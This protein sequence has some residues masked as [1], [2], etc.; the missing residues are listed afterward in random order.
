MLLRRSLKLLGISGGTF[1]S[2]L[3]Q[4]RDDGKTTTPATISRWLTGSSPVEPAVMGWLRELLRQALRASNTPIIRWPA[5]RSITFAVGNLKGGVQVSTIAV[6]L[7]I[8]SK[9]RFGLRTTHIFASNDGRR[10]YSNKV[11]GDLGIE[12]VAL[13]LP[14]TLKY[15]P[16][17]DEIVIIDVHR[18]AAYEALNGNE[19]Q[20]FLARFEPDLFL[21]P[22]DFDLLWEVESTRKFVDLPDHRAPIRVLHR[23]GT[24]SYDFVALAAD[25]GFDIT[26][27]QWV[28]FLMFKSHH[29]M[30]HPTDRF[31]RGW[32]DER[33][34]VEFAKLFT[35]LIN[36]LGGEM[37]DEG[38]RESQIMDFDIDQLATAL[39]M[40]QPSLMT[41]RR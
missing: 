6:C 16:A 25:A 28:P 4:L 10:D 29:G 7:A 31:Q 41:P 32:P 26:S 20:P 13:T 37:V 1:A 12:S 5:K 15:R 8:I 24:L 22:A 3:T 40:Q 11:L 14:Q 2:M 35:Y 9:R 27:S 17:T 33:Q 30:F 36:E 34:E 18:D 38:D 21:V 23:S 39:E 19:K